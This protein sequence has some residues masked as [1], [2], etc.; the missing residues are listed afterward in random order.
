MRLPWSY[1]SLMLILLLPLL[2]LV[3]GFTSGPQMD[4]EEAREA[5]SSSDPEVEKLLLDPRVKASAEYEQAS[6]S[7]DVVL[8]DEEANTQVAELWVADD[9]GKAQNVEVFSTVDAL[10][11]IEA[12]FADPRV[13]Q[14]L[15]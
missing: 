5:A 8:T 3:V 6:D 14:E 10:D 1:K 4:A 11:A 2:L 13:R 7:W 12:A 9:T 15:G